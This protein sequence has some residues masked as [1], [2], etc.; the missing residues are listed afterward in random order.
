MFRIKLSIAVL[1]L[2]G[3][4][5]FY[6]QNQELVALKLLCS[7]VNNSCFYQTPSLP[8]AAWILLFILAG[9]ITSLL[10]QFLNAISQPSRKKLATDN[11]YSDRTESYTPSDRASY[12]KDETSFRSSQRNYDEVFPRDRNVNTQTTSSYT[13]QPSERAYSSN[14]SATETKTTKKTFDRDRD[15]GSDWEDGESDDWNLDEPSK[16]PNST[17][18]NLE[19][20]IREEESK[21]RSESKIYEKPQNPETVNR[22]GSVYSF[23]YKESGES[24]ESKEKKTDRVYDAN[25]RLINPP[26]QTS[27]QDR[28]SKQTNE[29]DDDDWV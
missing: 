18:E 14:T 19:Q 5:L 3:I 2:A 20:S 22:S 11:Y 1:F 16:Q 8:I 24:G 17:R 15:E 12:S 21:L 29:E 27:Q 4:I 10:L 7:D 9:T 6:V 25:Y 13:S 23:K 26:I 28:Q